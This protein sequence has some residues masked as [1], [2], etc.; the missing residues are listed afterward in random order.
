VLGRLKIELGGSNFTWETRL[1]SPERER[2]F[3]GALKSD[4]LGTQDAPTELLAF[5][6]Y[7]FFFVYRATGAATNLGGPDTDPVVS[8]GRRFDLILN[9]T[10]GPIVPEPGTGIVL[11]CFSLFAMGPRAYWRKLLTRV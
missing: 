3:V 8:S 1:P 2:S 9:A 10:A 7:Y 4:P 11:A 6:T 5:N